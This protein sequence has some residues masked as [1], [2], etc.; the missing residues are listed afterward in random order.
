MAVLLWRTI[1]GHLR[2]GPIKSSMYSSEYTSGFF[3]P[4]A[5]HLTTPP[6]LRHERPCRTGSRS[7]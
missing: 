3:E 2:R 4:A 1:R 6:S 5:S 7:S